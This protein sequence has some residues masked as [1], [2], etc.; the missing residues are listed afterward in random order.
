M[1]R[2]AIPTSPLPTVSRKFE[3]PGHLV[4]RLH[5]ICNSIFLQNSAELNLSPV[6][7]AVLVGIGD[8]PGI[9]QIALG[10]TIALDRQTVSNVVN[11][12]V[13]RGFVDKLDRDKRS[14]ALFLTREAQALIAM[15]NNRTAT[16]DESILAPLAEEERDTFMAL[17]L[18]LV[19]GNNALSRAPIVEPM[20]TEAVSSL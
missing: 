17:L 12:L 16:I 10:R 6:Q 11:R 18:K 8:N 3:R 2:K 4:R 7:F 5:Q 14:K 15:M 20:E 9:E 1:S 19:N 13:A